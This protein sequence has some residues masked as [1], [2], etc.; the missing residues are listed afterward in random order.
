MEFSHKEDIEAPLEQVFA[1]LSDFDQIE[2]SILRRW[3]TLGVLPMT[4]SRV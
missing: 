3:S 2:R 1:E 4:S